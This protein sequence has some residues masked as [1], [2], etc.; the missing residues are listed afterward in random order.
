MKS[1]TLM[2]LCLSLLAVRQTA[3][4]QPPVAGQGES[5]EDLRGP[6]LVT[7]DLTITNRGM[8]VFPQ[9]ETDATR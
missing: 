4:G 3:L 5:E 9:T 2:I 1:E 7:V 6:W 8:S